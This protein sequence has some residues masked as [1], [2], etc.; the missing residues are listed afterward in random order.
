M[1][2]VRVEAVAADGQAGGVGGQVGGAGGD[3][4][5]NGGDLYGAAAADVS[6]VTLASRAV[7]AVKL[8]S[9]VS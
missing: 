6:T 4:R 3:H 8:L 9:P 5:G 2:R 1:G 7:P